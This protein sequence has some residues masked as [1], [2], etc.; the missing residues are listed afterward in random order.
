VGVLILGWLVG[1]LAVAL[2]LGNQSPA[3]PGRLVPLA[4][5]AAG[6]AGVVVVTRMG[7]VVQAGGPI[8]G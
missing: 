8:P 6:A 7:R 3:P 4:L 2:D 5:A 1:N